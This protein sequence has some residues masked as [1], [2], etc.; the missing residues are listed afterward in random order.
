MRYYC[1]VQDRC[2]LHF[3]LPPFLALSKSLN[4]SGT[5][6][7]VYPY[8]NFLGRYGIL[9]I[10]WIWAALQKDLLGFFSI[11]MYSYE[12]HCLLLS[13]IDDLLIGGKVPILHIQLCLL[14]A[15]LLLCTLVYLL[16]EQYYVLVTILSFRQCTLCWTVPFWQSIFDCFFFWKI[17]WSVVW[18]LTGQ[19]K[20][21]LNLTI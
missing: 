9:L 1:V 16:L 8:C 12:T 20:D 2:G 11:I 17:M 19:K 21:C 5:P 7:S 14:P 3:P 15:V 4:V 18:E 6:S 13:N 10:L